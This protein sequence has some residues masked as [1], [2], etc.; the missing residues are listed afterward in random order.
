MWTVPDGV[1]VQEQARGVSR[2]FAAAQNRHWVLRD[3]DVS[4][5]KRVCL[6]DVHTGQT[7][8]K[9]NCSS[10]RVPAAFSP[11]G[12]VFAVVGYGSPVILC[13]LYRRRAQASNLIDESS[14]QLVTMLVA[15]NAES[16]FDAMCELISRSDTCLPALRD[17][18]L[19]PVHTREQ[20]EQ[21][22]ADLGSREFVIRERATE[23]LRNA[24]GQILPILAR[25]LKAS[26]SLEQRQRL[27]RIMQARRSSG[28]P[29]DELITYRAVEVLAAIRTPA[30]DAL[31]TQLASDDSNPT[32]MY[33]AQATLA[34]SERQTK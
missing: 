1:L 4:G 16:A 29:R 2:G 25:S 33:E 9:W 11:D 10:T 8:R 21:H 5:H 17:Y 31:L 13:S 15:D 30:S 14:A 23:A 27:N 34:R 28:V 20:V 24:S 6:V 12:S 32:A 22:I 19:S 18:L 7:A 3:R 26:K